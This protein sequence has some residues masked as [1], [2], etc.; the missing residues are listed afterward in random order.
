MSASLRKCK[1][2]ENSIRRNKLLDACLNGNGE[3]FKEIEKMRMTKPVVATAMDGKKNHV[4]EHFKHIYERLYNSVDDKEKIEDLLN[5]VNEGINNTHVH[6]V[7]KVTPDVVKE[8]T[9]HLKDGKSDPVHIFSSDCLKHAPDVLFQL[10]SVIIRSFLYHGH[11]TVYLLLA[12]LVP[13]VKNKLPSINTSKNYR[14]IAFSS[15][16]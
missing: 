4:E 10:L 15:L 13:I 1:K 3:I 9:K 16:L 2:A 8:A 14:S 12:T 11:V 6:D 5:K 7:K